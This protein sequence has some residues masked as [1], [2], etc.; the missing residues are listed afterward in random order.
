MTQT[1][2]H[3][4]KVAVLQTGRS[5]D[6]LRET[7]GD[8]DEMCKGLIGY[9]ADEADTFAVLDG[10]FPESIAPYD[11]LLITGS[12]HGV[13]EDHE[14]IAPLEDLI[15]QA[16]SQGKK[17]IGV[18]FGHQ[19]IAKVQGAEVSKSDKGFG[20][21]VMDYDLMLGGDHP[22]KVALNAWHQ[23][24]V[25]SV[26]D[27]AKV[28]ATSDFCPIA[29]LQYGDQAITFQAHPEFSSDYVGRLISA[30]H[31]SGQLSDKIAGEGEQSLSKPIDDAVIREILA[32]FMAQ[33]PD[34]PGD[35]DGA[36]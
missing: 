23:D 15:R 34:D 2:G 7:H 32:E 9:S 10:E 5:P 24:Q 36:P 26:P 31:K 29:G 3:K 12:R 33:G 14:W 35:A 20:V 18:C 1:I 16:L 21:G 17:L 8:Y 28:I 27:G 25:E 11:L 13:Y 22:Q 30:R 19:I 6:D 4:T